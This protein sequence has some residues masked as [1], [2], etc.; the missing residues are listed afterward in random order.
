[1]SV[2]VGEKVNFS[3]FAG[4]T[5]AIKASAASEAQVDRSRFCIALSE[6]KLKRRDSSRGD[7]LGLIPEHELLVGQLQRQVDDDP[8]QAEQNQEREYARDVELI[9]GIEDQEP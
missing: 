8:V 1:M 5:M 4:A 3:A 2:V 6:D 9:V 7:V